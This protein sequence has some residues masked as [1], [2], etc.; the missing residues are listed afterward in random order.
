MIH[1]KTCGE[2]VDLF[3]PDYWSFWHVERDQDAPPFSQSLRGLK[4]PDDLFGVFRTYKGVGKIVTKSKTYYLNKGSLII[5]QI[6]D[7]LT[8]NPPKDNEWEY[9]CI[10]YTSPKHI[11]YFTH[12]T[13]YEIPFFEG[14]TGMIKAIFEVS[15][16]I[17]DIYKVLTRSRVTE[18]IFLWAESNL[19]KQIEALPHAEEVKNCLIYI[20]NNLEKPLRIC[21]LAKKYGLSESSFYRAFLSVIGNS[22]KSYIVQ[23]RLAK[24]AFLL[25]ST[26]KTVQIIS[27]EIGYYS[28]FQFSRD[29]KKHYK[30]SP[31]KY[32]N[33]K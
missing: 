7:I 28:E 3:Q 21:E 16:K 6:S 31:I 17:G 27:Y 9:V 20:N 33:E 4:E 30:L 18:L 5:L 25:K 13:V 19:T 11:P 14:E 12:N 23:Q 24:A 15:N 29:F 1:E 2:I 26:K 10:N 8:Y 32:R 22:P